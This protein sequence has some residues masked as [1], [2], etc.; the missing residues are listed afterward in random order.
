MDMKRLCSWFRNIERYPEELVA[1]RASYC[2]SKVEKHPMTIHR[3]RRVGSL[4][5][6]VREFGA[7]F[8][9]PRR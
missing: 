5:S 3:E 7:T 8:P 4:S 2:L 9:Q 6:F 1:P